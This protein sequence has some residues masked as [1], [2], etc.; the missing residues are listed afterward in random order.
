MTDGDM[1]RLFHRLTSMDGARVPDWDKLMA[2]D[3]PWIV[4]SVEPSDLEV[5]PPLF[6]AFPSDLPV[7][8]GGELQLAVAAV[9][10]RGDVGGGDHDE[11]GVAGEPLPGGNPVQLGAQIP[12]ADRLREVRPAVQ[13]GRHPVDVVDGNEVGRSRRGA[14]APRRLRARL[15]APR[16]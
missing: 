1:A 7:E 10:D 13:P 2:L 4:T 8:A 6:K 9:G 16:A 15:R 11:G 14:A 12:A 5:Q 3:D